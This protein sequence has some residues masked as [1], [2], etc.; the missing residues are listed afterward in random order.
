MVT[1]EEIS[2][3]NALAAGGGAASS[4]AGAHQRYDQIAVNAVI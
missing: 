4:L 2:A 1:P 3:V